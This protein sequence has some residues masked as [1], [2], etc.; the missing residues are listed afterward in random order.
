M[1][2]ADYCGVASPENVND[3]KNFLEWFKKDKTIRRALYYVTFSLSTGWFFNG[4]A[5][6]PAFKRFHD[7]NPGDKEFALESFFESIYR[8]FNKGKLYVDQQL[9]YTYNSED[10]SPM[11]T[12]GYELAKDATLVVDKI[13]DEKELSATTK[14]KRL[15]KKKKALKGEKKITRAD[16]LPV[17]VTF[18]EQLRQDLLNPR[19]SEQDIMKTYEMHPRQFRFHKKK[20]EALSDIG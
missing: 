7:L 19:I 1:T 3:F 9:Y 15:A 4:K 10:N 11:I 16:P 5:V 2:W 17:Y 12:L 6:D 13:H 18:E 8:P 14:A 20:L